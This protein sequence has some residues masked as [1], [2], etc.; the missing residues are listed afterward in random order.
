MR[1]EKCEVEAQE[2]LEA[3]G[4][5]GLDQMHRQLS[6][7]AHHQ[8]VS[9]VRPPRSCYL[10]VMIIFESVKFKMSQIKLNRLELRLFPEYS[11]DSGPTSQMS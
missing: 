3:R 4:G 8:F 2:R 7:N 9:Y 10:E 11:R 6:Q 5:C 1:K